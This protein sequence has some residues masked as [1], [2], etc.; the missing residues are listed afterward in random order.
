[1]HRLLPLLALLA[2]ARPARAD[3]DVVPHLLVGYADQAGMPTVPLR[4]GLDLMV[5]KSQ[6]VGL[7]IGVAHAVE[8]ARETEHV[9]MLR[10]GV[11]VPT[12]E[13]YVGALFPIFEFY[14]FAGR[15]F[16]D[17]RGGANRFGVGISSPIGLMVSAVALRYGL[18][19]PNTFEMALD[20]ER[21]G[22]TTLSWSLA[23]SL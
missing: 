19:V 2:F 5:R 1:M 3:V 22:L 8:L 6:Y 16:S 15:R 18:P 7:F 4:Y 10:L 20:R 13:D 9:P 12:S 17:G 23:W 14:G 21:D 11:A